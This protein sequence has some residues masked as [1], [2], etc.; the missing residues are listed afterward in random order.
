MTEEKNIV[1]EILPKGCKIIRINYSESQ[2]AMFMKDKSLFKK[3]L[4]EQITKHPEL[5]P[6]KIDEGYTLNGVTR[7]SKKLNYLQFQKIKITSTSEIFSVYPAF[8]MP[9]LIA[10]TKD[11]ENALLLRKH[12][13][14]YSTLTYI[15][16][17]N[18]MYWYRVE[19]AFA[20]CSI[21][22]TTVKKK[23]YYQSIHCQ[24][25]NILKFLRLRHILQQ[26]WPIIV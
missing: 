5:F 4:D 18:E 12:D 15:F 17:R 10:Y 3:Y 25:K 8:V 24:M 7:S 11:V 20:D 9:Y 26:Q 23:I 21:V 14:P 6:M 13:V 16:G 2:H 1:Y 19:Q 22:G